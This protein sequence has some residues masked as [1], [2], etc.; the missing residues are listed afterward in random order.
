MKDPA[1]TGTGA[2]FKPIQQLV[3][4]VLVATTLLDGRRY[5]DRFLARVGNGKLPSVGDRKVAVVVL[6]FY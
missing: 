4:D 2:D 5:T 3:E 6:R 1:G